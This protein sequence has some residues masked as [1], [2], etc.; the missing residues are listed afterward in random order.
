MATY[1]GTEVF[2]GTVD[3]SEADVTMPTAIAADANVTWTGT[4]EF[5]AAVAFDAAVDFDAAVTFDAAVDFDAG[6][7]L[8]GA[9]VVEGFRV[10]TADAALTLAAGDKLIELNLTTGTTVATMT[11]IEG[12]E[13]TVYAGVRSGNGAC[14]LACTRGAGTGS[15]TI[16]AV[17]EG[18]IFKCASGV[19]R[20]VSLLGGATFA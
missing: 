9:T 18:A 12:V 10:L 7:D 14:T 3:M 15:V 4:H 5:D 19:W 20:L 13:I 1:K 16:D 17:G 2:T 8:Q 11:V 6:V